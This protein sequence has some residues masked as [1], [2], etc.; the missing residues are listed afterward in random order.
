M[1]PSLWSTPYT[2]DCCEASMTQKRRCQPSID[3]LDTLPSSF[4]PKP[5]TEAPTEPPTPFSASLLSQPLISPRGGCGPSLQAR[6]LH[7]MAW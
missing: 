5:L 1:W 6:S 3:W 2:S 7:T 4:L